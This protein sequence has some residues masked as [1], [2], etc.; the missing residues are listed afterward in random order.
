MIIENIQALK[1]DPR[2]QAQAIMNFKETLNEVVHSDWF[3]IAAFKQHSML[4]K[5][6]S[7]LQEEFHELRTKK[8][9]LILVK[10]LYKQI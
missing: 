5:K 9:Y 2:M 1:K 6:S 8:A 4:N 10:Y 3:K 7:E